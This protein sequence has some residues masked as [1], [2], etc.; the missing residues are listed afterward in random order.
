LP[1][2]E[3]AQKELG[4]S[5]S[6]LFAEYLKE[7]LNAETR[8]R[9]EQKLNRIDETQAMKL[10]LAEISSALNLDLELHPTWQYPI[11]DQNSLNH[12]Y[13]VH[14]T[15]ANPDRI[16]SLVVWPLDFDDSGKLDRTVQERLRA[17]IHAFWDGKTAD[18]HKFVNLVA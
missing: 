9:K 3:R 11:L 6:S 14:Q 18:V 2:W 8:R 17:A 10:S 1:I 12:G 4:E 16:I 5:I 7:R 15:K 13:K